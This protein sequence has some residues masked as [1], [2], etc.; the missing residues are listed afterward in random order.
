[1]KLTAN[2]LAALVIAIASLTLAQS[3]KD[4]SATKAPITA[5]VNVNVVP[6]DRERVIEKQNVIVRDGRIAE[7]G[8]ANKIKAPDGATRIDGTGT[9]RRRTPP[10]L[11]PKRCSFF[12]SPTALPLFVGCWAPRINWNCGT[13]RIAAR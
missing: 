4:P 7:I 12:T 9:S 2:L 8:P 5:F 10:R 11:T 13:G 6:M 3:G 1:M